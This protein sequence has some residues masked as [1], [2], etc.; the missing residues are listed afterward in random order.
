MFS[1]K[2]TVGYGL[3]TAGIIEPYL[4]K[5]AANCNI[6]ANGKSNRGKVS[7]FFWP[8]KKNLRCMMVEG[9]VKAHIYTNELAS[10]DA[11][12]Y[13]IEAFIR[14]ISAEKNR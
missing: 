10:I 13:N 4:F 7:D 3:W 2:N 14:E 12:Q 9:Y 11:F 6:T 1:E 8:K 5:D